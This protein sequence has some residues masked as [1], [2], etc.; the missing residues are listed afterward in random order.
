MIRLPPRSTRTDTLFP[1]TTLFRSDVIIPGVQKLLNASRAKGIPVVY[2]TT[3]YNVTEGPN[4]DMGLWHLK[5]PVEV[6]KIGS[7]ACAIDDRIAPLPD[8]Q[9]IVKTRASALLGTTLSGF[10]RP[11][12]VH[13]VY[14]T[15]LPMAGWV[16]GSE[17]GR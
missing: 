9:V 12:G 7:E 11:A 10:L 13:A 5:I 6:L 17:E 15:G 16:R 14:A 4:S 2:T 3:A 1:Y 8:E